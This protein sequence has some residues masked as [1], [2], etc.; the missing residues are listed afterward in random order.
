MSQ[1]SRQREILRRI[2]LAAASGRPR[3]PTAS[4]RLR[5]EPPL[6]PEE[7]DILRAW[8]ADQLAHL[9]GPWQPIRALMAGEHLIEV[10][11]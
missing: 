5:G 11:P 6:S 3:N 9:C 2:A 1:A 10:F 7:W 8:Q 4:Q